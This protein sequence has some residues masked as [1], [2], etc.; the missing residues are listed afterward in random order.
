[1]FACRNFIQ[2]VNDE[3][4]AIA[5]QYVIRIRFPRTCLL[6][7]LLRSALLSC[8]AIFRCDLIGIDQFLCTY[9]P[10]QQNGSDCKNDLQNS[11][12]EN[13]KLSRRADLDARGFGLV[14]LGGPL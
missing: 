7:D 1:M 3:T 6:V 12:L 11:L 4:R 10:N 5:R 13:R 9:W 14:L 8:V 2:T